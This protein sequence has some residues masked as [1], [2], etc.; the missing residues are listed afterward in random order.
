[1]QD[2]RTT[3]KPRAHALRPTA[4]TELPDVEE[5]ERYYRTPASNRS[6]IRYTTDDRHEIIQ[7]GNRRLHI[8]YEKPPKRRKHWAVPVGL[9]MMVML[10]LVLLGTSSTSARQQHQLVSQYEPPPTS[11]L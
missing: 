9:G 1:M 2:Y 5:D 6:A 10:L 7:Q 4:L 11:P 8:H 3:M